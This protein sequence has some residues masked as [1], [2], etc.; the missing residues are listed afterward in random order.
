MTTGPLPLLN[1]TTAEQLSIKTRQLALI[2]AIDRIRDG[3]SFTTRRVVAIQHGRECAKPVHQP[4]GEGV[5]LGRCVR[6]IAGGQRLRRLC[7]RARR[8]GSGRSNPEIAPGRLPPRPPVP[9]GPEQPGQRLARGGFG[10]QLH[11]PGR[12]PRHPGGKG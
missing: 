4:P 5:V 10:P 8:P 2:L 7:P 12:A 11:Q 1:A 3:A 9:P 6:A